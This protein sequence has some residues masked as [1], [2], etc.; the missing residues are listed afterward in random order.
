[1]KVDF[2]NE[3]FVDPAN[4]F[5][6]TAESQASV[7]LYEEILADAARHKLMINLHGATTATGMERT[8]PNELT[9]EGVRGLEY[10]AA[11][12][13]HNAALPFT[14]FLGGHA[15]YTPVNFNPAKL[16]ATGTSYAHQLALG[17]L[18]TSPLTHFAFSPEQIESLEAATPAAIDYLRALPA[19]WDETLVLDDSAIGQCAVLARR[20]AETWFLVGINGTNAPLALE[21]VDLEFLGAGDYNAVVLKDATQFSVTSELLTT[22]DAESDFDISMLL[23]GGFVAVFTPVTADFNDDGFVDGRDFLE[24]QR[25]VGL[26]T[27]ATREQGNANPGVDGDV[28]ADDLATWLAQFG[29]VADATVAA[30]VPEP[31]PLAL[32]AIAMISMRRV[33]LLGLRSARP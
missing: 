23:G 12:P 13:D 11:T 25:G 17:G 26:A 22:V 10:D 21:D 18:Y 3:L 16:T 6:R 20:T 9:R 28:D 33:G 14:R 7:R 4:P 1:V 30:P 31:T 27:G 5:N 2:F 32:A 29:V 8:Y 19:V 24:W 15:D